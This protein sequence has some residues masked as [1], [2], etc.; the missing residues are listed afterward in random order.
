M[1]TAV[2]H[3]PIGLTKFPSLSRPARTSPVNSPKLV[4]HHQFPQFHFDSP[5]FHRLIVHCVAQASNHHRNNHRDQHHS[6][7]HTHHDHVGAHHNHHNH[8]HHHHHHGGTQELRGPQRALIGF[9]R[10][11]GWVHLA[12]FL[13]EHLQLCCCATA[14][15]LAAAACPYLVPKPA[16]KS[17]QKTFIFIGFPLVGVRFSFYAYVLSECYSVLQKYL[18]FSI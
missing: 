3:H 15:F 12:N 9:A 7:E 8:D 14:L 18:R 4:L 10:T 5:N 2:L 1:E 11:I 6:H 17:L 16:V 13:R